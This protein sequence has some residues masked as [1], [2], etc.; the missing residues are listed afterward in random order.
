MPRLF[1]WWRC[2]F[3]SY[4][5]TCVEYVCF[6]QENF[7]ADIKA[8]DEKIQWLES[9]SQKLEED[10]T[11]AKLMQD[12]LKAINVDHLVLAEDLTLAMNAKDVMLAQMAR[13]DNEFTEMQRKLERLKV[14]IVFC[15]ILK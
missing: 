13:K 4:D 9:S 14:N 2:A 11:E 10:L 5:V 3:F 8:K 6:S 12:N 1:A 7:A 15:V